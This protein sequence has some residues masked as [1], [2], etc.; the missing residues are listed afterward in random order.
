MLGAFFRALIRLSEKHSEADGKRRDYL[1]RLTAMDLYFMTVASF[2]CRGFVPSRISAGRRTEV[3]AYIE[4]LSPEEKPLINLWR[5]AESDCYPT[6]RL[7]SSFRFPRADDPK[8]QET[9]FYRVMLTAMV[10]DLH[11]RGHSLDELA[12]KY[13]FDTG[14][15]E[16]GLKSAAT[17]VL[18]C[19][20]QICNPE[21]CYNL[22]FLASKAYEQIEELS[23][24]SNLGK[25]LA[26][27]GVG[28][29]SVQTVLDAGIKDLDGL[30]GIP[31]ADLVSLGLKFS[32]ARK[33]VRHVART[34]R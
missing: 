7:L 9:Q 33:I 29:K 13:R 24:G 12:Q 20:A 1:R 4:N 11:A 30:R 19:L 3:E 26:I 14:V 6:R 22:N 15:L 5:S 8:S 18:H 21:R 2:E 17:W 34:S 10:L 31:S 25:L 23:F 32:Q 28:R 16:S 27:K